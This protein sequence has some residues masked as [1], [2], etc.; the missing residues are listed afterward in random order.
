M[1]TVALMVT[2]IFCVS[3]LLGGRSYENGYDSDERDDF[4][5]VGQENADQA[6]EGLWG[7]IENRNCL[8]S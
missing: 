7:K 1:G 6:K 5:E 4:I 3:A 8:L 2:I